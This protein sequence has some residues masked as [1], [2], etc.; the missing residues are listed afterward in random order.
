MK[1]TIQPS[2]LSERLLL[3]LGENLKLARLRRDIPIR[4][5]A[6]RVGVS[7]NTIMSL[8][9]G[10]G[11]VSLSVLANFLHVLGLSN[12]ISSIA[13]DDDLGRKLQDLK[14]LPRKRS[15]KMRNDKL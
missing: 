3:Q 11:G 9:K 5:M 10:H 13:K 14:I 8:E 1:K 12:D 6:E 4:L 15:R 2:P 7:S